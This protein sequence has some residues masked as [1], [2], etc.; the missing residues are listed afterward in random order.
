MSAARGRQQRVQLPAHTRLG[1]P[2]APSA[3]IPLLQRFP[4]SLPSAELLTHPMSAPKWGRSNSGSAKSMRPALGARTRRSAWQSGPAQSR[5]GR[6]GRRAAQLQ[7]DLAFPG[8][9]CGAGS[10]CGSPRAG[11]RGW[12]PNT[13]FDRPPCPFA[14]LHLNTPPALAQPRPRPRRPHHSFAANSPDCPSAM[15]P[16][17]P[18]GRPAGKGCRHGAPSQRRMEGSTSLESA[19]TVPTHAPPAKSPTQPGAASL[20][21]RLLCSGAVGRGARM[22]TREGQGLGGGGCA[23]SYAYAGDAAVASPG[24]PPRRPGRDG[25]PRAR[26]SGASPALVPRVERP[27]VGAPAEEV[28]LHELD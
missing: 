9:G 28:R 18:S 11:G 24:N 6:L 2:R 21:P 14:L 3:D 25:T 15:R 13:A 12:A 17:A 10:A 7:I 16:S 27:R 4:P 5:S 26:A 23:P 1:A 19:A 22:R 8:E 20:Q